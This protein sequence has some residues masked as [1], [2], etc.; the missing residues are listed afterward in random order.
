MSFRN[1][2][3]I[4]AVLA[5]A[6]V[7]ASGCSGKKSG[8]GSVSGGPQA[9]QVSATVMDTVSAVD[10]TRSEA[11]RA[12]AANTPR[13]GSVTQSSNAQGTGNTTADQ[14]ESR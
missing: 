10:A 14:V 1:L 4:V 3:V 12:A 6:V 5:A 9:P 2:S 7:F 13:P 11:A 8:S